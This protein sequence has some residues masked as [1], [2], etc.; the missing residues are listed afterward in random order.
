MK[1][2]HLIDAKII[3]NEKIDHD[4]FAMELHAPEIAKTA[5]AGQFIMVYLDKGELLLPRPISI[6]DTD[7]D[8]GTMKIIYQVV[9]KGT[10]VLS[11]LP[12]AQDVKILGALGNGFDIEALASDKPS[13]VAIVGGGIGIPPLYLLAKTLAARGVKIDVYMGFRNAAS[14]LMD[15][16][17]NDLLPIA[18]K[19]SIATED[20]SA[21][22]HGYVTGVLESQG[23]GIQYDE[24]FSCGPKLMLQAVANLAKRVNTPCQLCMEERM[25][26][27]IGTCV[28]CVVKVGGNY[29]R[30]CTE[31]PV[32]RGD[33]VM[34]DG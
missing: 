22:Y 32:F 31:G 34:C 14:I 10:A 20:G 13:H 26:C 8:A 2:M 1:E 24:I 6:Y 29:V 9:G 12:F 4:I 17:V 15:I 27:G 25:A 3:R 19:N 16:L 28:G 7:C 33:E 5:R 23:A 18:N 30:V 21:G 11:K